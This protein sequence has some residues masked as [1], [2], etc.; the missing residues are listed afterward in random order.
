[1]TYEQVV[2]KVKA[3]FQDVDASAI[4]GVVALQI[5][6][7]GKSTNGIFY[8]EVKDHKV[9]VEPYEYYD[10]H[11][12]VTVNPTNLLKLVEGKLD[13]IEAYNKGKVAI[14]GDAGAVLAVINLAK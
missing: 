7:E 9:N 1:M 6:L 5:N 4:D 13:P 8:I 3:K 10:R 2:A 14:D 12:I 11:A